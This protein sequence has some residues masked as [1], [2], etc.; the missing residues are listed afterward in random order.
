MPDPDPTRQPT[1]EFAPPAAGGATASFPADP[2]ATRDFLPPAAAATPPTAVPGYVI[3][4]ELGRGGMGV[5]YL[6]RQEK[7]NRPVALKMILAGGHASD[8]QRARFLAEAEAVAAVQH[9]GIVQVYEFGAQDGQP[10]F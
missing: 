7:L 1:A 8:A 6:A 2:A 3:E 10:Y 9:P 4:R 5:V